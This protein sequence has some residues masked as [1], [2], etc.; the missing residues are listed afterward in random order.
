MKKQNN[1]RRVSRTIDEI[2][3]NAQPEREEK[4]LGKVEH[5][6][7]GQVLPI[8]AVID[9]GG[10]FLVE[11]KKFDRSY[12]RARKRNGEYVTDPKGNTLFERVNVYRYVN[13]ERLT[14]AGWVR[15]K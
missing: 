15:I 5:K 9:N 7:L 2:D 1:N 13:E 4:I 10:A 8:L 11:H 6:M 3:R 14:S 12:V